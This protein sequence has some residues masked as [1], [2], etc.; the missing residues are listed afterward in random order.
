MYHEE[1]LVVR[2][3]AVADTSSWVG[4]GTL[5]TRVASTASGMHTEGV[6]QDEE[7]H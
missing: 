7:H 6:G 3:A 2:S 4:I 5:H 1:F